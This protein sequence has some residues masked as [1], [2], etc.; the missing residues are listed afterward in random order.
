[1]AARAERATAIAAFPSHYGNAPI[2]ADTRAC[3]VGRVTTSPLPDEAAA[4]L[5]VQFRPSG[6][7][8]IRSEEQ[9]VLG[10]V[11]SLAD[12]PVHELFDV[13]SNLR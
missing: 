12:V 13:V 11:R 4:K 9:W 3:Q 6:R 1:M 10:P 2:L 5:H 8:A 7:L